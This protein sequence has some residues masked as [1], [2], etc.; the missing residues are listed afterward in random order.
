[1]KLIFLQII[2]YV[3]SYLAFVIIT[4]LLGRAYNKSGYAPC[5]LYTVFV[6][7][8]NIFTSFLILLVFIL[9]RPIP[10]TKDISDWFYNK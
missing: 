3:L 2:L 7:V 5:P 6:P 9:D 10:T 8:V 4:L 1:M